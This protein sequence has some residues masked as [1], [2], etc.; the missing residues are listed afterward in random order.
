MNRS[1]RYR[2][3]FTLIELLV[4]IA[5]IGVLIA[6]L[7]PAVQSAREA[8]RRAQCTNNLKQIGIAV[9]NYESTFGS[10]P[11]GYLFRGCWDQWSSTVHLLSQVEQTQV[12]NALNFT[13]INCA[14]SPSN[15]VNTTA[16]RVQI[17]F[18]VCPSDS[19]D[20]TNAEGH[21]NYAGNWG[22]RPSA[23]Q[24]NHSGP[25][26]GGPRDPANAVKFG[27]IRD[28]L[29]NTACYSER[30]K[31]AGN[32]SL[33]RNTT[34]NPGPAPSA[35]QYQLNSTSDVEVG[36]QLYYQGCKALNEAT[37]TVGNYGIYGGYWHQILSGNVCYTHVMPPN[38][39]NC[40]YAYLNPTNPDYN[41]PMGALSASSRHPGAV[42]VLFCDGSV[43]AIKETISPNV[44]WA[45][46]S[47]AGG[48][49]VSADQY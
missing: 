47:K 1:S 40:V 32:G 38:S 19:D 29:S 26:G 31:G 20:L 34:S 25:F 10:M 6:L 39:K 27:A 18:L 42:N 2:S 28:G 23:Y 15:P 8:A 13:D 3:G 24:T 43:K 35:V 17:S 36:P 45:L 11:P 7:L 21:Y 16:I 33:L 44:W 48:E 49:V 9:H 37:A 12:Y 5:I 22:S 30:V 14:G 46:G 4:V 41:H